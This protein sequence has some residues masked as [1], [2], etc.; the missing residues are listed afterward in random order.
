MALVAVSLGCGA[1]NESMRGG[2]S[3]PAA[4][5]P[6]DVRT[7]LRRQY[8][9]TVDAAD[10]RDRADVVE[11][12]AVR[13][14]SEYGSGGAVSST[15]LVR[16]TDPD[17]CEYANEMDAGEPETARCTLLSIDRLV[18]LVVVRGATMALLGPPGRK[19]P[20]TYDATLAVFVD[21]RTGAD[22]GMVTL[23]PR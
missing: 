17:D 10:V 22:L 14:A 7:N 4:A 3:T 19:G 13:V 16:Y 1:E 11:E 5:V 15:H 8:R 9:I 20:D 18:W 6:A 21:A 23:P 2:E 12:R